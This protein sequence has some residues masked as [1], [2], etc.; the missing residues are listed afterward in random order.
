PLALSWA[1]PPVRHR[2]RRSRPASTPVPPKTSA[3]EGT[4]AETPQ[5]V[6]RPPLA[7]FKSSGVMKRHS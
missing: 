7:M 1:P 4:P 6:I 2:A 5:V 3:G